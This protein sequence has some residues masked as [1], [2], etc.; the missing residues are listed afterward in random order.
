M[1]SNKLDEL[2]KD[3]NNYVFGI[4]SNYSN[5]VNKNDKPKFGVKAI[6]FS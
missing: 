3:S 6:K 5:S 1:T 2:N 4:L